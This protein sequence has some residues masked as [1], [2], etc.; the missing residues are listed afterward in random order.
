MAG[1]TDRFRV[2]SVLLA[3]AGWA[4]AVWAQSGGPSACGRLE[5]MNT[6]DSGALAYAFAA[7]SADPPITLVLLAGGSGHVKLD[8]QGCAQQ[9]T[10][11]SL[12]RSAELFQAAGL[13][14]A[15]V[16]APTAHQGEDG[17][18]GYRIDV[19]HARDLGQLIAALRERTRGQVWVVGTSRG[20][21]SAANAAARLR[22]SEAPDG[23]VLTS[24]VTAGQPGARKAWVAQSV[25]DLSLGDIRQPLLVIAHADDGCLRSPP[26]LAPRIIEQARGVREQMVVVTGGP[27][28]A[29]SPGLAA[30]EGRKPHGFV[31]QEAEV[32]AGIARFVRG[33]AY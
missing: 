8:A 30:C 9:L 3:A 21:I 28:G 2:L 13:G 10:G 24:P 15:V 6:A 19:R 5:Q 12:L 16:D 7:P 33:A 11:N 23:V 20:A 1:L 25:F 31:G 29:V 4:G 14:T 32:A 17:L 18:G 27:T 26:G 22:G